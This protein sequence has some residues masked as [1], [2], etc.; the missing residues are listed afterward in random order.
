MK[1]DNASYRFIQAEGELRRRAVAL[2]RQRYMEVGFMPRDFQDPYEKGS[3][4]FVAQHLEHQ[5]VVGVCR[6]VLQELRT[7]PTYTHFELFE[8]ERRALDQLKPGTYT[9]LGALTKLPH[10]PDVT[11]GLI[12]TTLGHASAREMTHLLCCIDQ[13][14]FQSLRMFL[15]IPFQVIGKDRMFYG[16]IK[17]PCVVNISETL[18]RLK[19]RKPQAFQQL[20]FRRG[21]VEDARPPVRAA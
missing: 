3:I 10:H 19:A 13:Q 21:G 1:R 12:A 8:H 15:D 9:E 17:I 16:S 11:P 7:L 4:Y 20:S 6:L 5:Q 14:L 18:E 2:H